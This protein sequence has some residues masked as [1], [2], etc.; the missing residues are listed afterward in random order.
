LV[1]SFSRIISFFQVET[2]Q[3]GF[4]FLQPIA[5][6]TQPKPDSTPSNASNLPPP[7]FHTLTTTI[8]V[9]FEH[10]DIGHSKPFQ[11]RKRLVHD[12]LLQSARSDSLIS[13]DNTPITLSNTS[14]SDLL[15]KLYE[16]IISFLTPGGLKTWECALDLASYLTDVYPHSLH[17]S[18]VLE[19]GCGSAIPGLVALSN[20]ATVTFQDY[21]AEVLKLVTIPNAYLNTPSFNKDEMNDKFAILSPGDIPS[22]F[23][24]GD[25]GVMGAGSLGKF[26]LVLASETLYS[27]DDMPE[28]LNVLVDSLK[29]G[30]RA[31]IASK[32]NYFG[33]SGGLHLFKM[34]VDEREEVEYTVVWEGGEG[35]RREI[36]EVRKTN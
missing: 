12:A 18:S 9:E 23:V 31:I 10:L 21:N 14:S 3:M 11:L 22:F 5:P 27:K 1:L 8:E 34:M 15:P 36:L 33:C 4:S 26:D 2:W 35:V 32:V 30:G 17:Q 28:F 13:T 16:G 20:G 6:S 25:W 29:E 7:I 19:L 24:S